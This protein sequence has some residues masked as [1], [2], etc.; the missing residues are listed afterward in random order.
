MWAEEGSQ[1]IERR[2]GYPFIEGY[3]YTPLTYL[4]RFF[5]PPYST[6]LSLEGLTEKIED[7]LE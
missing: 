1:L 7:R 6:R 2:R 3:L 5:S 4:L